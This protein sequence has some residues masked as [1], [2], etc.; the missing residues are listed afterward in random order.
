MRL[1]H[2]HEELSRSLQRFIQREINPYVDAWEEAEAFPAH[3]LF[4][5]LGNAGF[6]GVSKPV[7]YGG[8]GLDYS[9]SLVV[10]EALGHI[11]CGAIPMAIGVHTD[12]ATPALARHGTDAAKRDF[13]APSISGEYVAC[14]GIS[15]TGAGSDVAAI[16]TTASAVE[17]DYVINGSKMWITNGAQADWMCLLANTGEGAPHRNKSLICV[18][19]KA[20]GVTVARTI[21]KIGMR[22]SDT[23][24]IHF[25]NVRVPHRYLIGEEGAGFTYQMQQFQEE[26]LWVA[27]SALVTLENAIKQTIEYTG[28]R[29]AFGRSILDNQVVQFRLA[30]LCT[31]VELLRSLTYRA[32]DL[33]LAGED[34]TMLASM[35]KLKAGRL[36][37]E[38]PDACLQYWGGMGFTW[39]NPVSRLY[40]DG[41]LDSIGGGA[42]EVMLTIIAKHMGTLSAPP[43]TRRGKASSAG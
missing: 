27:A 6:L 9:Y 12:M 24:E 20:T 25:D 21:R 41:R 11:A 7:E 14:L 42:D 19:M 31:E 5:K 18:P 33:H 43:G 3:D 23:A 22:A 15:E 10:A 8:M 17:G 37:R 16:R 28:Q 39:E 2:E 30:E 29:S 35:A 36:L 34:V 1:T 40:R 26:R 32:A 13:L 4:R 38:V